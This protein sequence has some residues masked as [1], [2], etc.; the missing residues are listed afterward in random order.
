M[1]TDQWRAIRARALSLCTSLALVLAVSAPLAGAPSAWAAGWSATNSLPLPLQNHIAVAAGMYYF[2]AGGINANGEQTGVYS[3]FVG[4]DGVLGPWHAQNP[5]PQPL[6]NH[7]AI[8]QQGY[9]VITGGQRSNGEYPTVYTA[10]IGMGGMLR[11]WNTTTPLP[12]PLFDHASVA[13][14]GWIWTVGGFGQDF[15]PRNVVYAAQQ[16]GGS[17]GAWASETPLPQRLG[18]MGAALAND[19]IYVAGGRG[20]NGIEQATV[21]EAPILGN[22]A[23][24]AWVTLPALPGTRWDPGVVTAGGYLWVIGG[25]TR[26]PNGVPTETN[27]VFR[28]PLNP[29]GTIGAWQSALP[30]PGGVAEHTVT[31]ARGLLFVAGSKIGPLGGSPTIYDAPYGLI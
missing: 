19:H 8:V 2:I 21:Y 31:V 30:L 22:G 20:A 18:E 12:Q 16:N 3:A 11:P 29:D 7:A 10:A 27:T 14:G 28:A 17:V 26:N 24:G 23:L 15:R 25:Y 6:L 13:R 5:L 4:S 9:V 1:R